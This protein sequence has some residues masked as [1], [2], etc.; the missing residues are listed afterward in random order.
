MARCMLSQSNL[1]KEWWG[2][3]VRT[4]MAVTNCLPSVRRGKV[5]P[6]QLMFGKRP[7]YGVF[8]PFGCK[9]WMIKPK[10]LR[11][12][13][14]D[15]VSWDGIVIGYSN[16]YL[17]YKVIR[18]PDKSIIETKHAYFDESVFPTLGA[19]NP[20]VDHFPHSGL[21]DFESAALF[22]FQEED[23]LN[24]FQD[25][26]GAP[27]EQ[28]EERMVLDNDEVHEQEQ[29]LED[30]AEVPVSSWE[31]S[32]PAPPPRRL[33]IHGPRHP[34]L[35]NSSVDSGNI[36]RY[37]RRPAVAFSAHTVEPRNHLQAM[38][39]NDKD[40]WVKAEQREIDNM[41]AHNVWNEVP[42]R[43]D[44][45]SIPSTWAYK[46]KL[47]SNNEV[48]EFKAR[49]CAQGFRQTHG[50][51]FDLKYAPTG[52]PSSLRLLLSFAVSSQLL[53]HQ[54]DVKSAF[55]T[56][57]LDEKVYL[58]PPAGYRTGANVFLALNK[59]IYGLKQ[60]S[61]AWYNR[62]RNFLVKIGFSASIADPCVFWRS[63]DLTWIFAH[64]DD[65]IIIS[66]QPET[67]VKQI[68][69]LILH[70]NQYIERKLSEFN[71]TEF[72]PSTCPIDPKSHLQKATSDELA[73][74]AALGVNYRALVGSL[75]Y[76]AILT[77]PDI[78][79]SVSKLSQFLEQPGISHFRAAVQV[80]RYLHHTKSLGLLF[81]TGGSEPLIISVD[82][83]WGNCPDTRRSHTGYLAT[84]NHHIISWKS[85][86]QSTISLSSTEAEYKALSD[87]GKEAYW[88]INL[89]QEI[90]E[91]S[92]VKTAVIEV[93][94]RGAIDL[95]R[96]QVSQNGFRTKHMDLWLH[97]IRDLICAKTISLKYVSSASNSS[98]FLTK[99]VG[100]SKIN[101]SL[102]SHTATALN[103]GASHPTVPSM[104]ACQD[105][106]MG[107]PSE[108]N[109]DAFIADAIN[110]PRPSHDTISTWT[111]EVPDA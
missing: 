56:C 53:I 95:A 18:L 66:K 94:N 1:A 74:F 98:Y 102:Q 29:P 5:S 32:L 3:A 100:R 92:P 47:G 39:S 61:L 9:T 60:A 43:P 44:I 41:L 86:K 80:F 90:F 45:V 99:P 104:G 42:A 24:T 108:S 109:Y 64:V 13:K 25:E 85:C 2:E 23:N 96:S 38:N 21:P 40:E 37:S 63:S 14:F 101:R 26:G 65:L 77:R 16:D 11:T 12:T 8:R 83:D 107:P 111:L 58:T 28:E 10:H 19:L 72:P 70:Q 17:A 55:L 51:N 22:P 20:S 106:V 69:G 46:K 68:N 71:F 82:A 93:D 62:L 79:Y 15:S 89:C 76:L 7:N 105:V 84:L 49:I 57:D 33:I 4:A 91:D 50:L 110:Q 35:I 30:Q 73:Q 75:N 59:A 31:D 81:G 54:L 97:H 78:A 27:D 48:V 52:K 6:I 88:L 34:T 87:A 67:F 36:L 103:I